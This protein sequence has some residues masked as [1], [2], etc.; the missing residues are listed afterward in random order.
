MALAFDPTWT[1][2][3]GI[4]KY[5]QIHY[6]FIEKKEGKGIMGRSRKKVGK[7]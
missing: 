5:K 3:R 4:N 7:I 6:P 1:F 2:C